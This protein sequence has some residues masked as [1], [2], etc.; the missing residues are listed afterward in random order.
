M[1]YQM[2]NTHLCFLDVEW[3]DFADKHLQS[4]LREYNGSVKVFDPDECDTMLDSELGN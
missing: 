2:V 4:A 1:M 3:L